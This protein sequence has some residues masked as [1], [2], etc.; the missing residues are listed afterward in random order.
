MSSSFVGSTLK[1]AAKATWED[2]VPTAALDPMSIAIAIAADPF[3]WPCYVGPVSTINNWPALLLI[4]TQGAELHH[5]NNC[6]EFE[7]ARIN[8][9][10]LTPAVPKDKWES[11][12]SAAKLPLKIRIE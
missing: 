2:P 12:R 5:W 8:A 9:L 4:K 11:C 3:I 6:R 7:I 1:Q 10:D